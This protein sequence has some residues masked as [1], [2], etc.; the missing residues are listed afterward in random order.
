MGNC[1]VH[2]VPGIK[3]EN[4]TVTHLLKHTISVN[5]GTHAGN[6]GADDHH[7]MVAMAISKAFETINVSQTGEITLEEICTAAR[8]HGIEIYGGV[9]QTF[10]KLS[11]N[12]DTVTLGRFIEAFQGIYALRTEPPD[13]KEILSKLGFIQW[14]LDP[15]PMLNYNTD[16][17]EFGMDDDNELDLRDH[18]I[19]TITTNGTNFTSEGLKHRSD[20][21]VAV[22]PQDYKITPQTVSHTNDR[23]GLNVL[24]HGGVGAPLPFEY[25]GSIVGPP[26]GLG[27]PS[28]TIPDDG[29]LQHPV[30]RGHRQ[31]GG[32]TG[33]L[34][35]CYVFEITL[36]LIFYEMLKCPAFLGLLK[37]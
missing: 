30:V 8:K 32:V 22:T 6:K 21:I 26:T 35:V 17:N 18:S 5:F 37:C 1:L 28:E 29:A 16:D 33:G 25:Q 15:Q 23:D 20:H 10:N 13:L 31:I 36:D 3:T 24:Q 12:G 7:T 27:S 2:R 14:A 4:L 19:N 34:F 9:T 11:G